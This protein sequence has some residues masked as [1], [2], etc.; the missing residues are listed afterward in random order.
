MNYL[1]LLYLLI[2][3]S[4]CTPRAGEVQIRVRNNSIY[5]FENVYVD[6]GGGENEYGNISPDSTSYYNTFQFAYRYAYI[7]LQINGNNYVIQPIDYV[8]EKKIFNGQYTYE[9]AVFDTSTHQLSLTFI[10]D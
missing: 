2:F 1:K 10:E 3:L 5:T 4:A 9:L 8:G 6:T 7:S